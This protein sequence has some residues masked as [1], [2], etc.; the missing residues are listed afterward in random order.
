MGFREAEDVA[1]REHRR[2]RLARALPDLALGGQQPVAQDRAQ[3]LL[4]HRRHLVV[5]RIVDQHVADQRRVVGDDQRAA[6]AVHR[7]PGLVVGRL[8]PEFERVA[9]DDADHLQRRRRRGARRR[10]R[11][12]EGGGRSVHRGT[13]LSTLCSTQRSPQPYACRREQPAVSSISIAT[14]RSARRRFGHADRRHCA[15]KFLSHARSAAVPAAKCA[16]KPWKT[17]H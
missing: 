11:R 14:P 2:H 8:A 6:D 3:D 17:M 4:A 13:P 16:A 15:R 10:R 7:Y 9:V 1:R 5:L 12:N